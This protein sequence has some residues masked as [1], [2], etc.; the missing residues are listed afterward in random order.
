MFLKA[1]GCY[2]HIFIEWGFSHI[3]EAILIGDECR[4]LAWQGRHVGT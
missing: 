3:F 1:S 2:L 4:A